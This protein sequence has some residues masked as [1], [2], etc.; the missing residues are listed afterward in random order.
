MNEGDPG[1]NYDFLFVDDA[2]PFDPDVVWSDGD[3]VPGYILSEG[4]GSESDVEAI[5]KYSDGVWV[6]EFRRAL[7]TGNIDDTVFLPPPLV[8]VQGPQGLQGE[9]GSQGSQG[10]PG[11]Q[12]AQ[13]ASGTAGS[14]SY[15]SIGALLVAVAAVILVY[16]RK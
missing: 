16:M 10:L 7:F 11:P 8:G 12:G 9:Q 1:T 5:G 3:T 13:G 6:V 14:A 2:V 15:V 4:T